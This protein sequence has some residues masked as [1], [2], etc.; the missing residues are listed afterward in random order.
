MTPFPGADATLQRI[1]AFDRTWTLVCGRMTFEQQVETAATVGVLS[2]AIRAIDPD[3][4]AAA[5]DPAA[6]K[7]W[8][9][10]LDGVET[11]LELCH[12]AVGDHVFERR[13]EAL[14]TAVGQRLNVLLP[15]LADGQPA[16]RRLQALTVRAQQAALAGAARKLDEQSKCIERTIRA[17]HRADEERH[18]RYAGLEMQ[19]TRAL[20]DHDQQLGERV[21][22][23]S[24]Q[25]ATA[26][27]LAEAATRD[28]THSEIDALFEQRERHE[29]A[30]SEFFVGLSYSLLGVA[31]FVGLAGAYVHGF[32]RTDVHAIPLSLAAVALLASGSR[33]AWRGSVIHR[34]R[35]L[36]L[37]NDRIWL[38]ASGIEGLPPDQR[39]ALLNE[40][41]SKR[42]V[43]PS[44]EDAELA[45]F[46]RV[47]RQ[48]IEQPPPGRDRAAAADPAE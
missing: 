27:A 19:V 39:V 2:L 43:G 11:K 7:A 26:R 4:P 31:A 22:A 40:H 24:E 9:A 35:H 6:D 20:A 12:E 41:F 1:A 17:H 10:V 48:V 15:L 28:R 46:Y 42:P 32:V 14:R 37:E 29:R 13:V 47:A 3:A 8:N 18:G 5:A 44:P 21:D 30:R 38:H 45:S 16:Q 25:A 33:R 36:Q 34:T 23:A